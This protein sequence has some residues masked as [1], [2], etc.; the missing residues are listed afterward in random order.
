MSQGMGGF[1]EKIYKKFLKKLQSDEEI[2]AP[3]ID[4]IKKLMA[5]GQLTDSE[6]VLKAYESQEENH[7]KD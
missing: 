6:A 3:L 7:A 1:T 5:N 4:E 2:P